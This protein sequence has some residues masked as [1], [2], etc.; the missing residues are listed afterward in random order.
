MRAPTHDIHIH[1]SDTKV[2]WIQLH[3]VCLPRESTIAITAGFSPCLLPQLKA[4]GQ[5]TASFLPYE[6]LG[7]PQAHGE[8]T[9]SSSLSAHPDFVFLPW[10]HHLPPPRFQGWWHDSSFSPTASDQLALS[11]IIL[12]SL[13]TNAFFPTCPV[14]SWLQFILINFQIKNKS[15]LLTDHFC[16]CFLLLPFVP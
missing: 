11:S 16:S 13:S 5:N 7:S 8:H 15:L 4:S 1:K 6:P 9:P 2:A 14:P 3:P 12:P 10:H